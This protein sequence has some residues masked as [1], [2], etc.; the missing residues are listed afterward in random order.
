MNKLVILGLFIVLLFAAHTG[1]AQSILQQD[2]LQT[3][4]VDALTDQEISTIN[5]EIS[6]SGLSLAAVEQIVLQKGMSSREFS[7]LKNRLNSL[8]K[9]NIKKS[10]S[11]EESLSPNLTSE[12]K[13]NYKSKDTTS[14]V[15]GS[16]LFDNPDL[17]FEPN[18][19]LATPINYILGPGDELKLSIYGV[20]EYYGNL[21]VS[22]EGFLSVPSAGNIP[23][24]GMTIEAAT[25]KIEKS[26]SGIYQTLSTDQSQL[27]LT[28][29]RIRTI[30]VTLIGSKLP[31]TM[32]FLH[33]L[34]LLMHY[35]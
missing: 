32:L 18:L 7:N 26:L 12:K 35:F 16:H 19:Q 11:G 1:V 28:L 25:N 6:K 33:L 10:I 4:K 24:A 34:P 3:L 8:S 23:V 5:S 30:Q 21:K 14:L 17:N 31:E 29:S 9:D 15:F 13:S 20:Q 2:N 22:N 27:S